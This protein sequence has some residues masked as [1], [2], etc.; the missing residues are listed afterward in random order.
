MLAVDAT[1][2][3][4]ERLASD[5]VL[6]AVVVVAFVALVFA[7]HQWKRA[8]EG[9]LDDAKEYGAALRAMNDAQAKL[10]VETNLSMG[11]ITIAL[12]QVKVESASRGRETTGMTLALEGLRQESALRGRELD[13][14]RQR[15]ESRR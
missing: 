10:M 4:L 5:G 2:T 15:V 11:A 14:M 8:M 6:G 7:V 13:A 12:E 3:A 1:T 9:R